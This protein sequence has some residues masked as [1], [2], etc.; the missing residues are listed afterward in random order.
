MG[1]HDALCEDP[2]CLSCLREQRDDCRAELERVHGE[3]AVAEA[4]P[5]E[6]RKL[7]REA[8]DSPLRYDGQDYVVVQVPRETWDRMLAVGCAS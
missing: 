4:E 1:R 5:G 3:L 2:G 8:A 6:A 7:C